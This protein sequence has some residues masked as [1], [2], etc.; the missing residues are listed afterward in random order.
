[1]WFHEDSPRFTFQITG[2]QDFRTEKIKG[3]AFQ[4][5]LYIMVTGAG[6]IEV[7]LTLPRD[8]ASTESF[9]MLEGQT[10]PVKAIELVSASA[11]CYPIT[12]WGV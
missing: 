5:S 8:G 1:M 4:K 3:Y 6:T 7:R 2:P 12:V 11:E 9:V 10:I